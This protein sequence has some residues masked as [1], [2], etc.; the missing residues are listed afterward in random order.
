MNTF[1]LDI[2]ATSMKIVSLIKDKRG[3]SLQSCLT[4]V[5]PAKGIMSESPFDQQEMAQAIQRLI[6]D[7]RISTKLVN[8]ALP[9]NQV[10]T[11]VI[12]MPV[13]SDKELSSAIYWEAEQHIPAPLPTMTIDYKIL[14]KDEKNQVDPKMQ[15]L[16]V[17]APTSLIRRYQSILEMAGLSINIVETE[18]LS[19]VRSLSPVNR[20]EVFLIVS[21]GALS[22]SLAILKNNILV[23]SYT[24]PLGGLAMDRSIASNFGFTPSQAEEYKKV[25]GIADQSLGGKISQA[26]EPILASMAT[27]VK[28]AITYYTEKNKNDNQ[29]SQIIL[30]GGS[31]LL[32]GLDIFFVKTCGIETVIGNPW[33]NVP[34]LNVPDTLMEQGPRFG[35]S[36]GLAM[37]ENE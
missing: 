26:L 19:V 27:E 23:F 12:D 29:I 34:V 10:F 14:Q 22:T 21:I 30:T 25:Y 16:L 28:K 11:K 5:T 18:V 20:S 33:K 3:F 6:V 8:V 13:L 7:A 1:G 2:G 35:V 36:V 37:R 32:P 4:T 15:V 17:G 24:I 31:S 9:E